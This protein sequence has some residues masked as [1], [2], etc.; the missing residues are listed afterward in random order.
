[1][2]ILVN[3]PFHQTLL[4]GILFLLVFLFTFR[5]KQ[6]Y[7]PL[8]F[9]QE[10]KGLAILIIIFGHIGYFLSLN[11]KFLFPF[12]IASGVGV[13]LFLFL[14]GYGIT[15]SQITKEESIL[16]FYKRR[17]FKLFVPFWIILGT[18]VA[19]GYLFLDK[20]YSGSFLMQSFLG[21]FTKAN[22]FTDINSPF[23]YFTFI[24]FYYLLFP[25]L[26]IKKRP[27]L[28]AVLLYFITWFVVK[29]N[30]VVLSGVV[31][32]YEVHL[33]AFPLGII[34][35][36]FVNSKIHLLSSVINMY[37]KYKR[38]T[39]PLIVPILLLFIYYFAIHS[40]IGKI[41]NI[42]Q[43][44]SLYVMGA[45]LLLFLIKKRESK[46][47]SLFGR[48]SYEIYL[49]HWPLIYYYDFLYKYLPAWV[50]TVGYLVM[51]VLLGKRFQYLSRKVNHFLKI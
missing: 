15:F 14:S 23:W 30:P 35:A 51:F 20:T 29:E 4:F 17:L 36:W 26:F 25:L 47:F 6:N 3:N 19:L 7:T 48:Y 40:E 12:S 27:W 13:N 10:L 43:V 44:R 41:A 11:Q 1:M 37:K 42:E 2:Q 49:F 21:I 34:G 5:K 8:S 50:A 38:F 31:G 32:L 9:T 39:Y 22:M 18:L 24:L 45:L 33:L 16:Q 28:T 46:L